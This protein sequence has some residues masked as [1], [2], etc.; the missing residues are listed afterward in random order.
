MRTLSVLT[1]AIV[2]ALFSV[3]S[4]SAK[5]IMV[6]DPIDIYPEF[7]NLSPHQFSDPSQEH[8]QTI[9]LLLIDL[10]DQRRFYPLIKKSI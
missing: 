8:R 6:N 2:L 3:V 9:A 7:T 4:A 5:I 1:L 10:I